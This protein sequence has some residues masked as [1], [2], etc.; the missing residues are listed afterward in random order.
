M[1]DYIYHE[2]AAHEAATLPVMPPSQ[3]VGRDEPTLKDIYAQLKQNRSVLLYGR[4][5]IGKT[6]VA[7]TLA[8]A[9]T[10][11][12]GGTL[13]LRVDEDSLTNLIVRLGRAYDDVDIANSE[14]PIGMVG[15]AAALLAQHKP[16]IVIDGNPLIPAV[17]EFL[18]RVA[19]NLPAIV[20]SDAEA[21]GDWATIEI[22]PLAERDAAVLFSERSGLRT[23]EI[24]EVVNHLDRIPMAL[25]I[26]AGTVR[27]GSLDAAQLLTALKNTPVDD[28]VER[29]LTVGFAKLQPP[30]QGILLML[31]AT[32]AGSASLDMMAM[33]SSAPADKV[34]KALSILSISGFVEQDKR[35]GAPFYSLHP[36][37]YSYAQQHLANTGRLASLQE[38][39]KDTVL[40][41]ARQYTGTDDQAHAHLAVEMD[42]FLATTHWATERGEGD[43]ASQLTIALTQAGSFVQRR[44][45]RH[46]LLQLQEV[47]SSGVSAFPANAELP[48]E[49]SL[50]L[51]E[52]ARVEQDTEV[53][54]EDLEP[55]LAA[56][57]APAQPAVDMANIESLRAGIAAARASGDDKR[58]LEL[59]ERVAALLVEQ[60]K[61]NEA[62]AAYNEILLAHEDADNRHKIL[63]TRLNLAELM[64]SQNSSRAAEL[65]A[66]QGAKLAEELKDATAH[67]KLLMLLGDARQQLGES[68]EAIL[69]YSHAMDL[70]SGEKD[71]DSEAEILTRMGFAQLD[72]DQ[73]ETAIVTWDGALKL[74]KELGKRDAEGRILGGLGTAFGE[75]SRWSEAI[76][77]HTSAL[78]IA[79]EVGDKQEEGLQLSHL[80]YASK[81]ANKLGDA[82]LRY[83]QALHLA[84]TKDERENIVSL[85]VD[86]ARL[87][88]ISPAHLPIAEMLIDDALTHDSS[89]REVLKLKERIANEKIM[90]VSKNVAFK[91]V[92]GTAQQYAG[93][94]YS[95]LDEA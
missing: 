8:S 57:E 22:P 55:V 91:D 27:L 81:Q 36:L 67:A 45:Y 74:C 52:P 59:Q 21:A 82:V 17:T 92:K 43:V 2:A 63:E 42:T 88:L 24:V 29:A 37:V 62:L 51:V 72:D 95:L 38:K 41:Y 16:L 65:H 86:L 19:P 18:K 13:W 23:P 9:Y 84:Y 90:A 40:A 12:A 79:R 20:I 28:P 80:G 66:T 6:A 5:G 54:E 60:K 15:A 39:V 87:L 46:E 11:T 31:G 25:V 7:A 83:R 3:L 33:L 93:S 94:A 50:P 71:R 4:P 61:E 47:G 73:T 78:Y 1:A 70:A 14:T 56:G 75:L 77:Y 69:A 49:A 30:L 76:N 64:V 34:Q 32:F 10:Q 85:V 53:L 26:A 58:A 48:P 68:T 35:Y 89:D 44:G